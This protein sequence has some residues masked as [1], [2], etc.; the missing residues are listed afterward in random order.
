[1]KR[2]AYILMLV[3]LTVIQAKAQPKTL[4]FDPAYANGAPQAKLFDEIKY[5]PL[6]TTR[7]S[8][9]GRIHQLIVTKNYFIVWD[10]DTDAIYFFDKNGKFIKKYSS[11]GYTI[12]SLRLDSAKNALYISELN[13]N[14][15][16]TQK[17]VQAV[18]D[19]PFKNAALKYTK[20]SYYDL[21][22]VKQ[23]KFTVLKDFDIIMADPS[24]F[25][26]SNWVYSYIYANK[27]WEDITDHELKVSDGKRIISQYFP[28]SRQKSS[29]FYG[30]PEKISFFKGPTDAELLFTRPYNY[31]IYKLTPDSVTALYTLIMP[32]ANTLPKTFF[33]QSFDSRAALQ[34]YKMKNNS[35]VWGIENVIDYHNLLFFS[36]DYFRG[37]NERNFF[38]D[39]SDNQFYNINKITADSTNAFLPVM[40][41]RLQYFD[42]HYLYTSVS[43]TAMFQNFEANKT[44]NP[45]YSPIIQNYFSK[46][47]ATANPVIIAIKPKLKNP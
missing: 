44:R 7:E 42:D 22:D 17:D 15:S 21:N 40:G 28:Y 9:F 20:A 13:K 35:F 16:P 37:F 34:D 39:K 3:F 24:I 5:V 19:D 31:N 2:I 32:M 45:A 14:Y 41:Y 8:L 38:F 47:K 1:M 23:A 25:N 12:R 36:L 10:T 30:S 6:E 26:K 46:S 27:S 29:I 33:T 4:Y 18:L 43:S 11:K